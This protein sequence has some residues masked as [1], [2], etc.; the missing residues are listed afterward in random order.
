VLAAALVK[1]AADDGPAPAAITHTVTTTASSPA[2]ATGA[3]GSTLTSTGSTTTGAAGTTTSTTGSTTA[4]T[5]G[6]A[7]VKR[8]RLG[9]LLIPKAKGKG[10]HSPKALL[11]QRLRELQRRSQA[12]SQEASRG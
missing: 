2:A 11:E 1:L 4:T 7:G 3:T 8:S 5:T 9:G 12:T 10:T 6:A